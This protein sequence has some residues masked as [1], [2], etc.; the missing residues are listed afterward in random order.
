MKYNMKLN[1]GQCA[2]LLYSMAILNFP[3][4]VCIHTCVCVYIWYHL[5][6]YDDELWSLIWRIIQQ[7]LLEKIMADLLQCLPKSTNSITNKSIITSLGFLH[8]KNEGVLDTFCDTLFDKS[9]DYKLQDYSSILQTFAAL[10]YKSQ[11]AN[12]FTEVCK[13]PSRCSICY[14]KR[15]KSLLWLI[16]W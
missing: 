11:K 2:T 8:Y 12:T 16:H 7:V 9:I 4:K 13:E 14:V 6:K 15:L 3:D 1:V 10:Q 5:P